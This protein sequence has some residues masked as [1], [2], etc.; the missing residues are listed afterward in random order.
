MRFTKTKVDDYKEFTVNYY[1][2][3][4][5]KILDGKLTANYLVKEFIKDNNVILVLV[6]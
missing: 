2:N 1:Q 6:E 5:D 4:K 3:N